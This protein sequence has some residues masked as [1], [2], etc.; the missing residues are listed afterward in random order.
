[1]FAESLVDYVLIGIFGASGNKNA[2]IVHTEAIMRPEGII[3]S[4]RALITRI[5][6]DKNCGWAILNK[7]GASLLRRSVKGVF[8]ATYHGDATFGAFFSLIERTDSH[9]DFNTTHYE[10]AFLLFLTRS[11]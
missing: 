7:N 1:M 9:S 4:E 8:E 6:V 11:K 2:V 3:K 5:W 10:N